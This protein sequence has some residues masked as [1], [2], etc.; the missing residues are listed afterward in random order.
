[1]FVTTFTARYLCLLCDFRSLIVAPAINFFFSAWYTAMHD[2]ALQASETVGSIIQ[3]V[4]PPK[5]SSHVFLNDLLSALAAGLAFLAIP[6][7][8]ILGEL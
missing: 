4:D 2:A 3:I 6:E 5:W 8:A 7:T 1:M